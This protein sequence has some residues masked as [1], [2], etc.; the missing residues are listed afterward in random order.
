METVASLVKGGRFLIE[1]DIKYEFTRVNEL[2]IER[3]HSS[4]TVLQPLL[5]TT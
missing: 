4:A 1:L 3:D 5:H 2:K